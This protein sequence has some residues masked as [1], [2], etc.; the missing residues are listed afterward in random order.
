M[1]PVPR[2]IPADAKSRDQHI[3]IETVPDAEDIALAECLL[4]LTPA[5]RL[6]AL[7]RYARLYAL[8]QGRE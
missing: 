5:E 4:E 1:R 3:D 2:D 8:A 7:A 6:R